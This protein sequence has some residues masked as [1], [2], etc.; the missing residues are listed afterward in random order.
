MKRDCTIEIDNNG[1]LKTLYQD[2]HIAKGMGILDIER[3][4]DVRFDN[5]DQVWKIYRTLPG[6]REEILGL[7]HKNR[8]DAIDEEIQILERELLLG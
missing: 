8:E 4:S 3:A 1:N 2:A 6:G 5:A 7:P